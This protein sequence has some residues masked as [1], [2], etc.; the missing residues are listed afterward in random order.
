MSVD[1]RTADAQIDHTDP[2]PGY[3]EPAGRW[4]EPYFSEGCWTAHL[5]RRL[6]A[7]EVLHGLRD[8]VRAKT[9]DQLIK[10]MAAQDKMYSKRVASEPTG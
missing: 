9:Q 5:R 4:G 10:R 6:T 1:K 7:A 3:R 2:L 8:T